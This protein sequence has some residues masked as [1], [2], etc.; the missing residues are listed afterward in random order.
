MRMG[1]GLQGTPA[2]S[3]PNCLRI[4]EEQVRDCPFLDNHAA[5]EVRVEAQG[6]RTQVVVLLGAASDPAVTLEVR[7]ERGI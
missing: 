6:F 7:V 2:I 1:S 5:T 3:T 4:L